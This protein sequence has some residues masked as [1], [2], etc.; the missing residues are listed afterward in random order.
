MNKGDGSAENWL[1]TFTKTLRQE[2]PQGQFIVTHA[3]K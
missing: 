2:L 3:R 1:S